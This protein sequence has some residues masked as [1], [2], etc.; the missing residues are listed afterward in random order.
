MTKNSTPLDDQLTEHLKQAEHHMI[1]A[2]KL[3]LENKKLSRR[4]G[5]FSRLVQAQESITS[6]HTEELV[7]VRG[8][9]RPKKVKAGKRR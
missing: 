4:L 1:A 7:R 9:M 5:Y 2:V 8:P 6:L 3:F